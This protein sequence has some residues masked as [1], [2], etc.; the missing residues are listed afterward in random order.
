MSGVSPAHGRLPWYKK[1]VRETKRIGK[2]A[3]AVPTKVLDGIEYVADKTGVKRL[4]QTTGIGAYAG[5]G[6]S[7]IQVG[8]NP[9][10]YGPSVGVGVDSN[11]TPTGY[12]NQVPITQVSVDELT[13]GDEV[14]SRVKESESSSIGI[15]NEAPPVPY[16]PSVFASTY[17]IVQPETP[18]ESQLVPIPVF[19]GPPSDPHPL[20]NLIVA[21][22]QGV[23]RA[24][25]SAIVAP[26]AYMISN[27]ADAAKNF[28]I[29]KIE[30]PLDA[31]NSARLYVSEKLSEK[32]ISNAYVDS[33]FLKGTDGTRA[34]NQERLEG[35]NYIQNKLRTGSA[36]EKVALISELTA[37]VVFGSVM[38]H[39]KHAGAETTTKVV[40]D[41]VDLM[42]GYDL[43]ASIVQDGES[44]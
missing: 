9:G 4:V 39:V 41:R 10:P 28:V 15:G 18:L 37:T 3:E 30:L 13:M 29:H 43:V 14:L 5:A 8:I 17:V 40:F 6:S 42:H 26:I 7:G 33:V 16:D 2:Q 21:A 20:L 44:H 32:G 31:V 24:R 36:E 12:V 34:R 11:G 23:E 1:V 25:D 19:D 35:L 22:G 38:G 27:P